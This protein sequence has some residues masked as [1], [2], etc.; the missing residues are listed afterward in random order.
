[1]SWTCARGK[2]NGDMAMNKTVDFIFDF[3]SPNAY[4]AHR[5]IPQIFAGADVRFQYLPCLLGG[6]FK[7]TG[8]QAPMIAFGGIKNKLAYEQLEMKRFIEKY[9]LSKFRFNPNFPVN[10]LML[11]RGAVAADQDGRLGDY[12]EAGLKAMWEDGLKMDDP[13][14]FAEAM[15]A[16]GF[17]GS[18]LLAQTQDPVVKAKL[19]ENTSAAVERGAFGVPTFFIGDAMYFGKDRLAQ[20]KE[21]V[22][23]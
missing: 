22:A 17:D 20:I 15:T 7:A 10:T 18:A 1:M 11:M 16:A 4:L 21:A 13:D 2:K 6:I 5:A 9:A 19:V 14:A 12:I 23:V 3:A 8:N